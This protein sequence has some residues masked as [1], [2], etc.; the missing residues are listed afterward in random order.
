[1]NIQNLY[2]ELIVY[3]LSFLEESDQSTDLVS[4]GLSDIQNF[5]NTCKYFGEYTHL[6]QHNLSLA[7]DKYIQPVSSRTAYM[8]TVHSEM[9]IFEQF[10]K[11]LNQEGWLILLDKEL[12]EFMCINHLYTINGY[13]LYSKAA[14]EIWWKLYKIEH[15]LDSVFLYDSLGVSA[16]YHPTVKNHYSVYIPS[17]V[18]HDLI[19]ALI[20]LHREYTE[21]QQYLCINKVYNEYLNSVNCRYSSFMSMSGNDTIHARRLEII[22]FIHPQETPERESVGLVT[23]AT[24]SI[25]QNKT[26][27]SQKI[28]KQKNRKGI[29]VI[30]K[31]SKRYIHRK[32]HRKH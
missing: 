30:P 27:V 22:P 31:K 29:K 9:L 16:E 20:D 28:Y 32:Y 10:M 3:I 7:K 21:L 14:L 1:M 24:S 4:E 2:P 23:G 19:T 6:F 25:P 12:S 5:L 15:K 11:T 17:D 8:E 13:V 18:H 26:K